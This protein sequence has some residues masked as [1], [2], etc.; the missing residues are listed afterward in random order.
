MKLSSGRNIVLSSVIVLA[1]NTLSFA[2]GANAAP[3][4]QSFWA[5]CSNASKNADRAIDACTEI[6]DR[7]VAQIRAFA[8][9]GRA[10]ASGSN[11][12]LGALV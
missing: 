1:S 5:D 9:T 2:Q 10:I 4:D 11:L 12:T 3:V 6:V 7:E 8:L